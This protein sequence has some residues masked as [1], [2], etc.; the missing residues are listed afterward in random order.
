[1]LAEL[2]SC[3]PETLAPY[4]GAVRTGRGDG[5]ALAGSRLL[6][7]AG[8]DAVL[9]RFGLSHPGA[10]R[11]ALASFWSQWH[12]GPAI[13]PATAAMLLLGLVLPVRLD[14]VGLVQHPD[15]RTE[16]LLMS[17]EEGDREGEGFDALIAGHLVPLI[18]ALASRSGVSARLL[19]TNAAATFEWTLRQCASHPS[20]HRG[21]FEE[22]QNLIAGESRHSP[23]AGLLRL[24]GDMSEPRRRVC[25]LRYSLPGLSDCG[26]YCPLPEG[27]RSRAVPA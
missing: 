25:C 13:I 4:A 5:A 19:W 21:R 11:R 8:L 18:A 26:G 27:R 3:L 20:L 14:R 2:A 15:G 6:E 9:D 7:P 17:E 1:M 10:D 22:A 23:L 16:A 24:P 12:F